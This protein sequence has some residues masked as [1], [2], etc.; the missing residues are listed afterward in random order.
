MNFYLLIILLAREHVLS[1]SSVLFESYL[2]LG[3]KVIDLNCRY[4]YFHLH[5]SRLIIYN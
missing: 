1:S 2:V 3:F 4:A 5:N